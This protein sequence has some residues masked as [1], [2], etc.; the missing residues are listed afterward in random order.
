MSS[1]LRQVIEQFRTA[2]RQHAR[3]LRDPALAEAL[4]AARQALDAEA[5]LLL[6]RLPFSVYPA[7]P[8]CHFAVREPVQLREGRRFR[9]HTLCGAPGGTPPRGHPAPCTACLLVAERYLTDG[10]PDLELEL[11]I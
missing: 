5:K 6:H 4:R 3:D 10:P 2:Q 8:Q 1:R 11:G 9:G 7:T